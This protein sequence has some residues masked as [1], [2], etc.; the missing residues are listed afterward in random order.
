[1]DERTDKQWLVIVNPNAGRKKGLKDWARIAELLSL[2]EFEFTPVFTQ[3]PLHAI[4]LSREF[5]QNG[6]RKIIVVGGDGTMNEVINGLF[7]QDKY[8]TTEVLLGM[9]S[10]GTGNDWGRM[11]GVPS[12]YEEAISVLKNCQTYIQDAGQ[13]QYTSGSNK[14]NRYFINI[15]GMGF[16]AVVTRKSNRMKEKGRGGTLLYFVNIFSSMFNYRYVDASIHIDGK[17]HENKVF[18]LSLGIGKYNGG[19]MIQLPAAIADDGLFDVT[20][21]KKISKPDL[22]FSLKRLYNGTIGEH[23]KVETFTGKEIKIDSA[24]K[25]LLETDGESLGHTPLE[26]SIIPKS[27]KVITGAQPG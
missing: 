18:S 26:F 24:N 13:V 1:M 12:D 4:Q 19:G 9:I 25:L 3:R 27:V 14:A 17:L 21:I 11:F 10:V 2:Y 23:P 15:A 8:K 22:I 20:L 7:L 6:Y 5:I 16:D